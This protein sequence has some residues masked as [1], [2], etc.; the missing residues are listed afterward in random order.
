MELANEKS[1]YRELLANESNIKNAKLNKLKRKLEKYSSWIGILR[2]SLVSPVL[3]LRCDTQSSHY[4]NLL[5]VIGSSGS[6]NLVSTS[7]IGGNVMP[8]Q[9][10]FVFPFAEGEGEIDI[11]VEIFEYTI[12]TDSLSSKYLGLKSIPTTISSGSLV[13]TFDGTKR[14][15]LSYN[16]SS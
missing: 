7:L 14:L 15:E 16:F 12:S 10:C 6:T 3:I 5:I 2:K 8:F 9:F 1:A 13:V 11:E 4:K